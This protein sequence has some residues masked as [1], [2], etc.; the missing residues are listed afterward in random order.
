MGRCSLCWKASCITLRRTG[1][2]E[3]WRRCKGVISE[4]SARL[5]YLPA[6][7][8]CTRC[9][10]SFRRARGLRRHSCHLPDIVAAP[11]APRPSPGLTPPR[12]SI[13]VPETATH[14]DVT[15]QT[16]GPRN[17]VTT[18]PP[19][20]SI[21]PARGVLRARRQLIRPLLE[22]IVTS[23]ADVGV[24]TH[25]VSCDTHSTTYVYV[26]PPQVNEWYM[27]R[28]EWLNTNKNRGEFQ[29]NILKFCSCRNI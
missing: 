28:C 10:R 5:S 29:L 26:C 15:T 27:E 24:G 25:S 23:T 8:I 16:S 1:I 11:P 4:A 14:R 17:D 9:G 7:N 22:E 21:T 12:V 20:D 13:D 3:C 6:A 18:H 19:L 2:G